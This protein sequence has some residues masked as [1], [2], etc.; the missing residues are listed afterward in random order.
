MNKVI[1]WD[2]DGTLAHS[3]S[4]WSNSVLRAIH[5]TVP[6]CLLTLDDIRQHMQTG[7]TWHTPDEDF[8]HLID[9]KWWDFMFDR[10]TYIYTVL[11]VEK[12]ASIKASR[13]TRDIILDVGNYNLYDDVI[14][15]LE[16]CHKAGYKNYI[17]SNNYPELAEI[18]R[19]L[20]IDNYFTDY[21]ISARVGYDK[22]RI[23]LFEYA[24][25]LAGNTDICFMVGDNPIADILGGKRSG[26]KTVLVHNLA[27]SE[28]DFTFNDLSGILQII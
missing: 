13:I 11:G 26:M 4:L 1:F 21:V 27:E 22:P 5:S 3:K 6:N 7:F 16:T 25:K 9:S 2:F 12:E 24:K 20:G 15:T 28:A 8:T 18:V 17:L 23:E 19:G 10:F 14:S